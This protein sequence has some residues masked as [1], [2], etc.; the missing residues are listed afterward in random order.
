MATLSPATLKRA[1]DSFYAYNALNSASFTLLSG[2]FLTLFA[3][4]LGASNALVGLLN[5][6]GYITFF[7]LPL[8]KRLVRRRPI[9]SVFGWTWVLRNASMLPIL[10]APFLVSRGATGAAFGLVLAGA[11]LFNFFRGVGLIG[12]NPVLAF[13]SEGGAGSKRQDKGA[14]LVTVSIVGSLATLAANLA[15]ALLLGRKASTA[16]YAAGIGAG[17]AAGMGASFLLLRS[18]EPEDYRPKASSSAWRSTVEA[19]RERPFRVFIGVYVSLAFVAGMARS[20]LPVY[21]KEA[22]GQGDDAVMAYSFVGSIGA[23]A[24]G[25]L[26]RRLVDR[27]GA[28]PLYVIFTAIS[29]LSLAPLVLPGR[30]AGAAVPILL[31][32]VNFLSAFGFNGEENAGQTYFFALAGP[33]RM[34]DLG[35]LYYIAYGIG[36]S[37]GAGLG[38]VALDLLGQTGLAHALAYRVF[39]G[40]LLAAM[41]VILA[42][43]TRLQSLGSVSILESIGVMFNFRDLAAFGLLQRLD[44]SAGPDEEIRL[45]HELGSRAGKRRS[46]ALA[47]AQRELISYLQSPRFDVR[48]EAIL[49]LEKMPGLAPEAEAALELEVERQP[50]TTAYAAARVLGKSGC[51][52]AVPA[53]RKAAEAADYMLQG[54]VV[55]ALARLGDR[56]SVDLVE[57]ILGRTD[58]PRVRISA[59]YALEILGSEKSV[60]ALV[61]CLRRSNLPQFAGDEILLSTASILG[62]MP[63]FYAMYAAF[64]E[65]ESNGLAML[66][67]AAAEAGTGGEAFRRAVAALLAEPPDGALASRFILERSMNPASIVLSEAALD[68][69][70]GYR[71]LRFF[72]AV[73]AALAGAD[74][75][76]S[77]DAARSR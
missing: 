77:P 73:Y 61:S 74:E 68:P 1:R 36:G 30:M 44:E 35:V 33:A 6:L 31:V 65:D 69:C 52:A 76:E 18:P 19:L 20:F 27:L 71:G 34:L 51:A 10:A 9:V 11:A 45:I 41:V 16:I 63:R 4:S 3:L 59:A 75:T 32:S 15:I 24:M 70:L 53:L 28:K 46:A 2:S 57:G 62:M 72:I 60:P 50:F 25:M 47:R 17:V 42:V 12:N 39:Y 13:L 49:T 56:G 5:A 48:M 7:F 8:G 67:D 43:S 26:T 38:G 58:N 54:S 22:F 29:A 66:G 23:L 14:F 21:A 37:L 55:V 64:L 40:A